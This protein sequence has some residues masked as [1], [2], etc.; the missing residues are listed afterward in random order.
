M[1][2]ISENQSNLTDQPS[3]ENVMELMIAIKKEI[4]TALKDV[5]QKVVSLTDRV[6][7]AIHE[8]KCAMEL[9]KEANV[10]ASQASNEVKQLSDE[11]SKC[12]AKLANSEAKYEAVHE[13]VIS[14]DN[15]GRKEN[16]ILQGIAESKGDE[17]CDALVRKVM[18]EKLLL[19]DV[20]KIV[21]QRV[22][23]IPSQKS[24]RPI[25]MRFM[26]F[27][28]RERVWAAR[29]NLRKSGLFLLEDFA[30][31]VV[32]RRRTLQ[33]ILKRARLL[34]HHAILKGDRIV[35]DKRSY[36][37][38]QLHQ[39]PL[40]LQ[41]A[42]AAT[43]QVEDV[44]A[45]FTGATPLSNF[46]KTNVEIDGQTYS[47]VEQ[48]FQYSKAVFTENLEKANKIL[49]SSQ[50]ARC[51]AIGDSIKVDDDAWLPEAKRIM[52]KGCYAKF[53]QDD[54][55][56][57]TLI[58]TQNYVLAEASKDKI[59]GIGLTLSAKNI[60]NKDD[61]GQNCLGQTLMSIRAEM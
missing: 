35:I 22:H 29:T 1:S 61:W 15:Y 57:K 23:R 12:K 26:W 44:L 18:R 38:N 41:P 33:P 36:S 37:I 47:S 49:E 16:L 21:L 4:M 19:K 20:D 24:P 5:E 17:N 45:F 54:F 11:L 10:N 7:A 48:Y 55:A 8:S 34:N 13:H 40:E 3:N 43:R 52:R 51:K 31:E 50:P 32:D 30:K 9:A 59:W 14:M 27:A 58:D 60:A 46:Y 42:H 2:K 6:D 39:L 28:D 25:I 53:N 56:K